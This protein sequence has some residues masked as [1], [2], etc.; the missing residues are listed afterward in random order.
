MQEIIV[1]CQGADLLPIDR[2]L[3]F[4]GSLKKLSR[5]NEAKLRHSILT[6][7]F[8]APFFVW[9]NPGDWKLLDGHQRLKTLLNM[10]KEGF[11]IPLLPVDYIQADNEQDARKKLLAITSQYGEFDLYTLGE[12]LE[13][14][15][16]I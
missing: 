5:S 1:K 13:N 15:T 12:W 9:G 14:L 8:I 11:D 3:E 16:V 7:G 10:R 2:I 6:L 4:Q